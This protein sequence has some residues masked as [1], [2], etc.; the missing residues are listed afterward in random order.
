MIT[1]EQLLAIMPHARHRADVWL[2]PLNAAMTEFGIDTQRRV[3][4]FL[5]QVAHESSELRYVK[6]IASGADYD[7]GR[8]AARLGNT[9]VADGDG[10]RY[11]GRGLLQITGKFNYRQASIALFNDTTTLLEH[12]DLLETPEL[13]ARSAAWFW[14]SNGLNT[15][16]DCPNSFQAITRRINGGLNGYAER[17]AYFD[18]ATRAIA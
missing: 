11:K 6:E 18:T 13:A 8:L 12:P 10:Q 9:P 17:I 14:W 15:V 7:T 1:R 16:A 5:A 2:G 4:A 3:A